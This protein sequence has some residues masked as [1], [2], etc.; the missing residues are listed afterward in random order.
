VPSQLL[1]ESSHIWSFEQQFSS[2]IQEDTQEDLLLEKK[3]IK[4]AY[5]DH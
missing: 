5:S 3:N 4:I 2:G 1:S